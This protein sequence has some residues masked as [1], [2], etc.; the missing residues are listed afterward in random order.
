[1][2]KPDNFDPDVW[3]L[4]KDGKLCEYCYN[5]SDCR[6]KCDTFLTCED[7]LNGVIE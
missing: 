1:M 5:A 7:I 3:R 2:F 4:F 6:K